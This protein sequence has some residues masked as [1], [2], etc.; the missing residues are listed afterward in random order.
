MRQTSIDAYHEIRDRGLLSKRRFSVY[1][2]LFQ[3]GPATAGE[4]SRGIK[5]NR[6]LTASRLIE[7]KELGVV[8]EL[9]ERICEIS[10]FNVIL[11]DVTG[12]LPQRKRAKPTKYG[13]TRRQLLKE[14][15]WL[16]G[17]VLKLRKKVRN[18]GGKV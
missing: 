10:K 11:W 6:N 2:W 3:N 14:N 18:L 4:I 17:E 1:E 5:Y 7:L 8:K 12:Q 9:G 15:K 13:K 16:M